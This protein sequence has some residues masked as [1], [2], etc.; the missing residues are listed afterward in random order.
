MAL[1]MAKTIFI[2]TYPVNASLLRSQHGKQTPPSV[3]HSHVFHRHDGHAEILGE[4]GD[5]RTQTKN[6][7]R[8]KSSATPPRI[9]TARCL[10]GW[11]NKPARQAMNSGAP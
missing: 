11:W 5:D 6:A 2:S 9:S 8:M 10:P 3:Q 4:K 1:P 7:S